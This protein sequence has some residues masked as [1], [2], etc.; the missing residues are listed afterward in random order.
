MKIKRQSG[1]IREEVARPAA[2]LPELQQLLGL[3]AAQLTSLGLVPLFI[4]IYL[5]D[6]LFVLKKK[7]KS[8]GPGTRE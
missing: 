3:L 6:L 7:K 4:S 8:Q 5:F 1:Q 2:P